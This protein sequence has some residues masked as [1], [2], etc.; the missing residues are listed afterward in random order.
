MYIKLNLPII[1]EQMQIFVNLNTPWQG[2]AHL[3]THYSN[4]YVLM[5][6]WNLELH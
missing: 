4:Q 1:F 5:I 6:V 2:G 3:G